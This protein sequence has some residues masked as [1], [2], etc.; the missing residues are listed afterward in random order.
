M[1]S[2]K[3]QYK[4]KVNEIDT[5]KENIKKSLSVI[6]YNMI[7]KKKITNKINK[8]NINQKYRQE[9]INELKF[10]KNQLT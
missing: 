8:I 2:T 9:N 6:K 1:Q 3:N 5:R 10:N 7:N 4:I